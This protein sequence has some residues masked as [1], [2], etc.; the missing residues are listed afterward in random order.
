MLELRGLSR[1]YGALKAVDA[2]DLTVH[3]GARHALIGPN[4]AGKSTLLHLVAGNLRPTAG[5]VLIAGRDATGHGPARRARLG[6]GRT[7]QTPALVGTADCLTNVA[8]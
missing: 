2:V 3:S 7:F 1:A 6:V 5:R 8:L 4:G